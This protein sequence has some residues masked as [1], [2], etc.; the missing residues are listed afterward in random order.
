MKHPARAVEAEFTAYFKSCVDAVFEVPLSSLPGPERG[1]YKRRL[2]QLHPSSFPYCGYRHAYESLTRGPDPLVYLNFPSDYYTGVGS[3]AHVLF[4]RWLSYGGRIVGNYQ[5]LSC[6][7][8]HEL[9]VLPKKCKSCGHTEF[10]YKEVGG[11]W[12]KHVWWHKDGIFVDRQGQYWVLD[13]KTSTSNSIW[14]HKKNASVFPYLSNRMQIESYVVLAEDTYDRKIKGTLLFYASRDTPGWNHV[15]VAN[16]LTDDRKDEIRQRLL[17][18][19]RNFGRVLRLAEEP[20]LLKPLRKTKLCESAKFYKDVVH[21][22]FD[23]CPLAAH[24]FSTSASAKV[25]ARALKGIP[26]KVES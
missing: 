17:R 11:R 25:M 23:P 12:G 21:T 18:D 7:H 2:R 19:D 24:C 1:A 5:C 16:V 20:D 22:D 9:Q 10:L 8:V 14:T 4:Q 13:F 3:L 26:I 15:P 6:E